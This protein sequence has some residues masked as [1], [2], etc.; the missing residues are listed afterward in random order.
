MS[1]AY[2]IDCYER[3]YEEERLQR[4]ENVGKNH[5]NVVLTECSETGT[6]NPRCVHG[7]YVVG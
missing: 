2:M 7:R 1:V 4:F 3:P 6:E 5:Q